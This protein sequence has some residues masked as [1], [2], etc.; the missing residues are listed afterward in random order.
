MLGTL[1][2]PIS[3]HPRPWRWSLLPGFTNPVVVFSFLINKLGTATRQ[4]R[5]PPRR[6]LPFPNPTPS[7]YLALVPVSWQW[8]PPVAVVKRRRPLLHADLRGKRNCSASALGVIADPLRSQ[9]PWRPIKSYPFA[10]FSDLTTHFSERPASQLRRGGHI[11][12]G[13]Q[14]VFER[15]PFTGEVSTTESSF[16]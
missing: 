14:S 2:E 12:N 7:P 9:P 11:D 10:E 15:C 6:R 5:L 8:V 16:G 3:R 1:R 4:A 13:V